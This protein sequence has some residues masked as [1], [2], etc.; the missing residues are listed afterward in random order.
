MTFTVSQ[1]SKMHSYPIS[2]CVLETVLINLKV[3]QCYHHNPVSF[4]TW[5][6]TV[7]SD[8]WQVQA[9]QQKR[10]LRWRA[11]TSYCIIAC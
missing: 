2:V 1:N 10:Y 11:R 8:L 7:S 5:G 3:I 6:A 9:Q 4:C